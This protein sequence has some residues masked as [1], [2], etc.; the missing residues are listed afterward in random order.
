[1]ARPKQ[2]DD[3]ALNL[4]F[5]VPAPLIERVDRYCATLEAKLH[6]HRVSRSDAI[7]MLITI[8]LDAEGVPAV[9]QKGKKR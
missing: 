3:G 5:R 7:R 6:G 8:G 9:E 1:M 4:G 2:L